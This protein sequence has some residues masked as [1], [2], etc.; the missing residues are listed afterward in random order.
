ML[1]VENISAGYGKIEVIQDINI[2]VEEGE[3]VALVG[4]NGAGKST[5]IN[6]VSGILKPTK[7]NIVFMGENIIGHE[8]H[9]IVNKGLIQIPEGRQ[10][11]GDM[12]VEENLLMGATSPEGKKFK[13]ETL[14]YVYNL[15]PRLLERKRQISKTLSGGEQQMIAVGRAL[16]LKPKLLICDEI[17][18]GLAP[19]VVADMFN[20]ISGL[21][22]EGLTI[23]LI[24]QNVKRS[25]AIS[26]RAY[27]IEN[28]KIVL[29][30]LSNDIKDDPYIKQAY[31]GL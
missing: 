18:L 3:M 21:N 10:L 28:G 27:V 20:I 26:K 23:L 17:S 30:G 14:E 5:L 15:F 11:F 4:A 29:H 22:K 7:G 6:T 24:E 12:T 8:P 25:L 31:L 2:E 13:D 19:I 9:D 16:M 1:K